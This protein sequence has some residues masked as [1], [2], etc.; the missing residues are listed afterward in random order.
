MSAGIA[1]NRPAAVAIRAS[2]MPGAYAAR[3]AVLQWEYAPLLLNGKPERFILT[4]T[5]S[6]NLT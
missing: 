3:D 4:V 2:A 5:L 6:F 1:A